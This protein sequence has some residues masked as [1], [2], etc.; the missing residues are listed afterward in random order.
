M[1]DAA[2]T[3]KLCSPA[4]KHA[5][6]S[7]ELINLPCVAVLLTVLLL[8]VRD[9]AEKRRL[10]ERQL[11]GLAAG[12]SPSAFLLQPDLSFDYNSE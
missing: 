7:Q 1:N 6:F 9:A 12:G 8:Q 5:Y 3:A 11:Q 2:A 10:D 4:A